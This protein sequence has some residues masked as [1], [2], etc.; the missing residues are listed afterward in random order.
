MVA[1]QGVQSGPPGRLVG[2]EPELARIADAARAARGGSGRA[3]L[4]RG[5][6]GIGKTEV[7]CSALA[8]L[9]GRATR[10]L[11]A[12]CPETGTGAYAAVR[13]LLAPVH[14]PEPTGSARLALPA[15]SP[16]RT[17]DGA[18]TGT[19]AVLHGLHWLVAD[20]TGDGPL[21]LAVDDVQW[22]DE[23]SLR[24]L[25]FLLRRAEELPLLVLLAQRT[26]GTAPGEALG[27]I[28]AMPWCDTVDLPA[29]GEGSV[30][31]LLDAELPAPPGPELAARCAQVTGGNPFLLG[32]VL[33][34]LREAPAED[35]AERLDE[36]HRTVVLRSLLD[37]L[38]ECGVAAARA[39][40]TLPGERLEL[41]AALAGIHQRMAVVA[42]RELRDRDLVG[43]GGGI[44]F[45]HDFVRQA[46]LDR[47]PPAELE[48]LRERA[49]MLLN[50]AGRPAEEVAVLLLQLPGAPQPWMAGVLRD[51]ATRAEQRGAPGTAARCLERVLVVQGTDVAVLAQAARVADPVT[52]LRYL[53]RALELVDDPRA[54]L[55]IAVQYAVAS[56]SAQNSTRAFEVVSAAL[57][58]LDAALGPDLGDADRTLRTLAESVLLASGMDEKS[59]LPRVG[60]RFRDVAPPAGDTAEERQLLGML[61]SLGAL[62]NRP[63][64]E[65]AAQA[66][67]VLRIN[68]VEG[69]GFALLGASLP[70]YLADDNESALAA[71][72]LLVG[73]AQRSGQAWTYCL[74][75]STRALVHHWTGNLVEALADAQSCYD[76]LE[77]ESWNGSMTMP[78]IALATSLTSQGEPERATAVL[79]E[80]SRARFEDFALEYH[81]FLMARARALEAAGD[82][83]GALEQLFRCAQSLR[84][85]GIDNPVFAPWWFDAACLLGDL[86]RAEEG[87]R[88]AEH[89]AVLARK[90][91]TRRAR[92]MALAARG[93]AAAGRAAVPVLSEAV[94]VLSA[95]PAKREQAKAEHLLGRALLRAGEPEGAREHLRSALDLS[96][97]HRDHRQVSASS[98]A[99]LEAG[100]RLRHGTD[101]PVHTLS[102]S[103]R[104]VAVR[105]AAGATNRVIAESL[106][107]TV[108]TVELHLTSAYR[109][110]GVR[111]RAEL[112]AALA[113]DPEAPVP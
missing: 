49:A 38:S 66:R 52:G 14:D 45:V 102:G 75:T 86:G 37:R 73:H 90:W 91:G 58:E 16:E 29:L 107:L 8:E 95:S 70:L 93:A 62:L 111:G 54:R 2:R 74:A 3:V 19:Y 47:T 9:D 4:L 5:P 23:N 32:R 20:L 60:A 41:I 89:G 92:G 55:P 48:R 35:A 21:V 18:A 44:G 36:L 50:D 42:L 82:P 59:T 27:E 77:Q 98:A 67:S 97:L 30:A 46:V 28:A 12:H 17:G 31:E 22:C 104:R 87:A 109:K 78:Q 53:E 103:E 71:L 105:A 81:Q 99:L 11:F 26:G 24:F 84:E 94:R 13:A 79:A 51:A 85:A 43:T 39:V 56:L 10:T 69:D 25:A 64:A 101:S 100:G 34:R 108:R 88:A 113:V 112:P 61:A 83:D 65:V 80:I 72:D 96:V 68:D 63:A 7:L 106:F 15:L 76:V 57:D 6:A 33:R 40:A 1:D 110:L